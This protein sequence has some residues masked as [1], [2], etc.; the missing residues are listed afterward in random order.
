MPQEVRFAC[1]K[2]QNELPL[3]DA[4]PVAVKEM[5]K[6][7]A[8]AKVHLS[9]L[10]RA[11]KCFPL[12]KGAGASFKDAYECVKGEIGDTIKTCIDG[13]V[14]LRSKV[15]IITQKPLSQVD[16]ELVESEGFGG[17][18]YRGGK[19]RGGGKGRQGGKGR[20]G[21]KR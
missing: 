3:V 15:P 5:A 7:A 18:H 9:V 1:L 2:C 11:Q 13:K 8:R 17:K 21:R 6:R 16:F 14:R 19:R 12:G 4:L 10:H 20:G